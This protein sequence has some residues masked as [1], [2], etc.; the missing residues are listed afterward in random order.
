MNRLTRA[1]AQVPAVPDDLD[2]T[3]VEKASGVV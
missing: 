2:T 1:T 3:D